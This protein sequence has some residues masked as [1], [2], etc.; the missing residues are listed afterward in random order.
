ML[1]ELTV[2]L[3]WCSQ[4]LP[5]GCGQELNFWDHQC[6]PSACRTLNLL[7]QSASSHLSKWAHAVSFSVFIVSLFHTIFKNVTSRKFQYVFPYNVFS[8]ST[9]NISIIFQLNVILKW[10]ANHKNLLIFNTDKHKKHSY[11][12]T[13]KTIYTDSYLTKVQRFFFLFFTAT[14]ISQ[15][16]SLSFLYALQIR[17]HS[18]YLIHVYKNKCMN[19]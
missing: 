10:L 13:F 1:S 7:S 17:P 2:C 9:L 15:K 12:F 3:I 19:H 5:E 8:V 16:K 18:K 6:V 4:H 14:C 11:N